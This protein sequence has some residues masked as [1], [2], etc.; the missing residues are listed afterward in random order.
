MISLQNNKYLNLLISLLTSGLLII[1]P[2]NN[3]LINYSTNILRL[4]GL[5]SIWKELF[6]ILLIIVLAFYFNYKKKEN[7]VILLGLI[8]T[9]VLGVYSSYVNIIG[10]NRIVLGFRFE[11]LWLILLGLVITSKNLN[12]RWFNWSVIL[13]FLLSSAFQVITLIFGNDKIYP[14]FGFVNGWGNSSNQISEGINVFNNPYCH[15]TDGG[16]IPCR[17]TGGLPSANNYA[18]YLL[19]VLPYFYY[20]F[21]IAKGKLK[22]LYIFL[23][24]LSLV[25][26]LLTY[27]RFAILSLIVMILIAI[28]MQ[29]KKSV[30][31]LRTIILLF[32]ILLPLM[33]NIILY[34]SQTVTKIKAILPSI[35]VKE[36]S[37]AAHIN[38]TSLAIDVINKDG[39]NLILHGYGI[40]ETGP[41]AKAEYQD[42]RTSPYVI[43]NSKLAEKYGIPEYTMSVPE[44]WYLQLILNGGWLYAILYIS[45]V[46]FSIKDVLGNYKNQ[47]LILLGLISII[48]A[49]LFLHIWESAVV[50]TYFVMMYMYFKSKS[51]EDIK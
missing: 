1:L 49:N 36:G 50:S 9:I 12:V 20:Q 38:L 25:F 35:L 40:S 32:I 19:L 44:N 28:V 46:L 6:I 18:G 33:F 14:L 10:L 4:S 22:F 13:G 34:Q 11:L 30:S 24:C 5:L 37:T 8:S 7:F 2:I 3:I 48:I 39:T 23:I 15:S 26:L 51:Y 45:I 27:S 16:I 21:R 42:T 47:N 29:L 17:L 31:L 43:K 41:A